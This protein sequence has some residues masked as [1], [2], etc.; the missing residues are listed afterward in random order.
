MAGA[1][2]GAYHGTEV[3]PQRWLEALE[4]DAVTPERLVAGADALADVKTLL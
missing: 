4:R 1:I 3:L 2:S